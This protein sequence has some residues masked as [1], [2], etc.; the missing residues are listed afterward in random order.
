M[1]PYFESGPFQARL[2]YNYRTKYFRTIGRLGSREMVAAYN[3]LDLSAGFNLTKQVTLSLN[4]QNS[5]TLNQTLALD[6]LVVGLTKRVIRNAN[7]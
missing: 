2:S 1:I 3:Q 6:L 7:R 4:A 5:N